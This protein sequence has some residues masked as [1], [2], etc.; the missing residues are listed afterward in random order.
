M[1][2]RVRKR[3]H[4]VEKQFDKWWWKNNGGY[5]QYISCVKY[6][7]WNDPLK[8]KRKSMLVKSFNKYII[9]HNLE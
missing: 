4:G 7:F 3:F 9:R 5:D 2:A 6:N 8:K 1:R